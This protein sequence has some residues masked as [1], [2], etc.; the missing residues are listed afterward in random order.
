MIILRDQ[1]LNS[2]GDEAIDQKIPLL[3]IIETWGELKEEIK[4]YD[5]VIKP[6]DESRDYNDIKTPQCLLV[7]VK[8]ALGKEDKF[9]D[10]NLFLKK[11]RGRPA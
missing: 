3:G 2:L 7:D 9:W 6:F 10:Y 5:Y 8:I 11:T 1:Y 4:I